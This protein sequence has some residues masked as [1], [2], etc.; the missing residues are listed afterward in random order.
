MT[1]LP[2]GRKSKKGQRG[3]TGKEKKRKKLEASL[4]DKER[5]TNFGK[6]VQETGGKER[7]K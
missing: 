3:K 4:E 5:L 1:N 6:W 2:S 7:K